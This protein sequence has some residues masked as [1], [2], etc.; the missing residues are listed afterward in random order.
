M[1][2]FFFEV[3]DPEQR[4]LAHAKGAKEDDGAK[5]SQIRCGV[6]RAFEH[7]Q[8][9]ARLQSAQIDCGAVQRTGKIGEGVH[10]GELT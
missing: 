6:G 5:E 1:R 2:S 3:P 10:R 8:G 9:E 4:L 7:R